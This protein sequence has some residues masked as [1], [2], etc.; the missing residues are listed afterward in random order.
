MQAISQ[1]LVVVLYFSPVETAEAFFYK[2]ASAIYS[3]ALAIC[4][5]SRDNFFEYNK[6]FNSE[7]CEDLR[8]TG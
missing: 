2:V 5:K 1:V 4:K 8:R 7:Y 6:Y 3:K